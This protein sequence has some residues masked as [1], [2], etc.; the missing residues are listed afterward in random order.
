MKSGQGRLILRDGT[1]LPIGYRLMHNEYGLWCSGTLI[2]DLR[3]VDPGRFTHGLKALLADGTYIA[4]LVTG[5]SDRHVTFVGKYEAGAPCGES[6]I[7]IG[8]PGP[9]GE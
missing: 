6:S 2:G 3:S 7:E 4:L 5:H 1:D 9:E 8:L